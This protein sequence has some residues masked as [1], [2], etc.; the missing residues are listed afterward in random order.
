MF[1]C[2]L[3]EEG[4]KGESEEERREGKSENWRKAG[5]WEQVATSKYEDEDR[6]F[7][8]IGDGSSLIV[9]DRTGTKS[10]HAVYSDTYTV[11]RIKHWG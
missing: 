6:G 3:L 5:V 10:I 7:A 4:E 1:G 8:S 9:K 2:V 11:V